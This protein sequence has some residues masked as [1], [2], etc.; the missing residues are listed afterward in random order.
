MLL[1][2][3]IKCIFLSIKLCIILYSEQSDECFDFII[4]CFFYLSP[5]RPDKILWFSILWMISRKELDL[6]ETSGIRI[7]NNQYFFNQEKK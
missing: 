4:M 3:N 6:V 7:K 1:N 2:I 5:F